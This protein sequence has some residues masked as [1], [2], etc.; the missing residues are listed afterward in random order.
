VKNHEQAN[1][2]LGCSF[3]EAARRKSNPN[4]AAIDV[5]RRL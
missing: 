4:D 2:A 5:D 3:V 1:Q